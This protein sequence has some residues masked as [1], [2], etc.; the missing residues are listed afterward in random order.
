MVAFLNKESEDDELEKELDAEHGTGDWGT[1]SSEI[2]K[3]GN[4]VT[5]KPKKLDRVEG[6]EDGGKI[7]F[8]V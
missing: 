6:M 4:K 2:Q 8:G 1:D 3:E 5:G 7:D